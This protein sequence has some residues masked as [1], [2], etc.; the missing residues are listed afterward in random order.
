MA[1]KTL[2]KDGINKDSIQCI[3]NA[4]AKVLPT[5][6]TKSF[7]K[8]ANHSLQTLELKERVHHIIAALH[9]HL[10]QDF[11]KTAP[12]LKKLR[13]HWAPNKNASAFTAWPVIDYVG[14]HGIQH[15]ELALPVLKELT[16]LF[17]AEF[18][19]RPFLL[20]HF[21]ITY[22]H[23]LKWCHDDDEHVRR[24]VSE[25]SRPRLPWGPRLPFFCNDPALILPLLSQLKNDQSDYVRRSVANNLN[26]ISRDNPQIAIA[27]CLA[28]QNQA[29]KETQWIIRHAT[30]SLV[31]A[32][33]PEV[34][35]L[36][37][38]TA[39][40]KIKMSNLNIA[41]NDIRLGENLFID[42]CVTST[43][44]EDQRLVI[45]YAIHHVK[46]NGS[47]SAK[48]FKLKSLTLP[49]SKSITLQKKHAFQKITTRQYY[50]GQHTL[51]ILI[52]GKP[53]GRI[54]F[55]LTV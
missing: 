1:E 55:G 46:A 9:Q 49:A 23:L 16:P 45:D 35:S 5:F 39:S 44:R 31:K 34:L 12:V 18:A 38:Y 11:K 13:Q 17:T 7:T 24:L 48:V 51:E 30:R 29:T 32:G 14:I 37:G 27:T 28:W 53:S 4:F 25:G 52:N 21:D 43:A 41:D 33:H 26:D 10:P 19:I 20:N 40:P 47:T 3:A 2:M 36:L 42:F 54:D 50:S 22:Q 15:P 6:D 8:T